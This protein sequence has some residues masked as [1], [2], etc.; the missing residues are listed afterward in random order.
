[1]FALAGKPVLQG[2]RADD[3]NVYFCRQVIGEQTQLG[4]ES[5]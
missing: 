3:G 4:P 2:G 1:M 5:A